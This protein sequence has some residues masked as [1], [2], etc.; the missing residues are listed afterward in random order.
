MPARCGSVRRARALHARRRCNDRAATF[1]D[2]TGAT[3]V[4]LTYEDAEQMGLAPR[5]LDFSA[6]AQ[7]ASG[8]ARVA[9]ITLD[10]VRVD[11]IIVRDVPAVG[12]GRLA[13][14]CSA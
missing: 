2:D 12:A 8:V 11:D 13:P 10:R 4:A 9:P 6:H 3:L 14:I 7:T 1:I 5:S